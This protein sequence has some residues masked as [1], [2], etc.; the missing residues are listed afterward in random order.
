[1]AIIDSADASQEAGITTVETN[2]T[3]EFSTTSDLCICIV[4]WNMNG[5]VIFS[6]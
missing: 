6:L 5:Q 2:K 4:T 1:M 3:C